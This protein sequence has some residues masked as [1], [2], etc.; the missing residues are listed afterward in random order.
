MTDEQISQLKALLNQEKGSLTQHAALEK[1]KLSNLW[2]CERVWIHEPFDLW[3]DWWADEQAGGSDFKTWAGKQF[4]LDLVRGMQ[5]QMRSAEWSNVPVSDWF[6]QYGRDGSLPLYFDSDIGSQS[7][8]LDAGFSMDV[9]GIRSR[10]RPAI[11][12]AAF[13]GLQRFRPARQRSVD[14]FV[15]AQWTELLP[16]VLAAIACSGHLPQQTSRS[17][18]FHLLYRTKYLKSFLAACPTRRSNND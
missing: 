7:S 8:S 6:S 12:L 14:S 1:Q 18:E 17:F 10:I 16:P 5:A 9:L 15:Y 4:V 11:E 13:I 3:I 2:K